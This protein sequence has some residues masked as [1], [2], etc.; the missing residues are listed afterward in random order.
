VVKKLEE[1]ANAAGHSTAAEVRA[2]V[3]Y[4]IGE[5]EA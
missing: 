5:H 4:W 3:R 1:L 2:A